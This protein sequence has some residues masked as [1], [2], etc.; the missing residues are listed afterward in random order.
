MLGKTPIAATWFSSVSAFRSLIVFRFI[1]A[2][3]FSTIL[4]SGCL[5]KEDDETACIQEGDIEVAP[6][7]V[8]VGCGNPRT[9]PLYLWGGGG[10]VAE[11]VAKVEV[12]RASNDLVVWRMVSF[13][14]DNNIQQPV[15]HGESPP[16]TTVEINDEAELAIDIAYIVRVERV[17]SELISGGFGEREFRVIQ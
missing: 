15:Q 3:L 16:G 4:I 1:S 5:Y 6:I 14:L 13:S 12:R 2:L 10:D 11:G 7:L 8:S 17:N 9:Q